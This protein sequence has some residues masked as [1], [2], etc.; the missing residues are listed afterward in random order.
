[1]AL[2][3]PTTFFS[4]AFYPVAGG[5]PI[6]PLS[7]VACRTL[8]SEVEYDPEGLFMGMASPRGDVMTGMEPG[9]VMSKPSQGIEVWY[10]GSL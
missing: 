2:S 6:P 9:A 10:V 3:I 8:F 7:Y 5:I 4:I 1:M